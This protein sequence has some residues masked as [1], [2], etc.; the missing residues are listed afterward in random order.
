V[1]RLFSDPDLDHG[2]YAL[3]VRS[4]LK[5]FGLGRALMTKLLDHA[6]SR[7]LA[8]ILAEEASDNAAF[9]RICGA[10]RARRDQGGL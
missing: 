6:Q 9:L 4:D 10:G 8:S 1:A 7:G 2:E 5:A 3:L